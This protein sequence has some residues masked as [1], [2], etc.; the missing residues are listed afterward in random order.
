[1]GLL[2]CPLCFYQRTFAFGLVGLLGV[3][4]VLPNRNPKL[5]C[6]LALPSAVGGLGAGR[7]A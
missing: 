1:M 6:I 4:L 2:A 7:C 3:G 5:L